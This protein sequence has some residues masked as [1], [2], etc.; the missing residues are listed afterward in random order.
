MASADNR[1][2]L[3]PIVE[4]LV[5][6]KPAVEAL[7]AS[8]G[9]MKLDPESARLALRVVRSGGR[10]DLEPL[11]KV[12][13]KSAQGGPAI[14]IPSGE[15]AMKALI[16]EIRAKGD[17]ARGE[18]VFRR[19]N[20]NCYKCH[21]IGPA[22]G[23]V[24]PNL[25]SLG[26]S[27]QPDYI[28]DSILQPAKAVKEGYNAI[29]VAMND[30]RILTGIPIGQTP[31]ELVIRDA[32]GRELK[33]PKNQID[34]QKPTGSLMPAGLVDS[35]TRQ[36][37]LDLIRFMTELGK[38]GPYSV[39]KE[40]LIRHFE[41]LDADNNSRTA[42]SRLSHGGIARGEQKDLNWKPI[43]STVSGNLLKSDLP[44]ISTTGR[45]SGA[46]ARFALDA[47]TTGDASLK[48]ST[49]AGLQI[50]LDGVS[51]NP[52]Q[53][54]KLA[55]TQGRHQ[56][57]IALDPEKTPDSLQI[58]LLDSSTSRVELPTGP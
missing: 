24:G 52:S 58:Q 38:I 13:E 18:L 39:P 6:S 54:L 11:A 23:L 46:F 26:A 8:A 5:Q 29:V 9:S 31:A 53:E 55:L 3:T 44:V 34:D 1:D 45:A 10:A 16:D 12:L 7:V 33:L 17:P 27:S 28:I 14:A 51:V 22:G 30:G 48:F 4:K 41:V 57:I 32:E 20:L 42:L 35:L 43:Y 40:R 19:A 56:L 21:G 50:W 2:E 36:E 47:R 37:L 15:V 25:Q 49:T